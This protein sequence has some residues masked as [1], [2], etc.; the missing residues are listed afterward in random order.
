MKSSSI[1]YAYAYAYNGARVQ[2]CEKVAFLQ[3]NKYTSMV[4]AV[5]NLDVDKSF[6]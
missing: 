1:L 6:L 4:P 2:D 5:L 3:S